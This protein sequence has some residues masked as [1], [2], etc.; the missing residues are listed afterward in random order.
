MN[1]L[2]L[3]LPPVMTLVVMTMMETKDLQEETRV[4]PVCGTWVP[5]PPPRQARA[6]PCLRASQV[7][8]HQQEGLN[9]WPVL[10][11]FLRNRALA[12]QPLG[13]L[14]FWAIIRME[15]RNGEF[16]REDIGIVSK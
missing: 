2:R 6:L 11:S 9:L 15:S 4:R 1:L 5:L 12:P 13:L 7:L 10:R 14:F 8:A 3:N 16:Q